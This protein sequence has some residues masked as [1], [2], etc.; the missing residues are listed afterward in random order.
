MYHVQGK[1]IEVYAQGASQIIEM[2]HQ[3]EGNT[4][5]LD[6]RRVSM[7]GQLYEAYY[8]QDSN[9]GI[10][11]GELCV[12]KSHGSYKNYGNSCHEVWVNFSVIYQ[13]IRVPFSA[14]ARPIFTPF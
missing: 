9:I 12:N 10:E 8:G 7:K 2:I 5:K 4:R 11:N 6:W 14:R 3:R 1:K 13:V